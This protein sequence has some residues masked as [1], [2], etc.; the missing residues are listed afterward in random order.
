LKLK[1][2]ILSLVLGILILSLT[3]LSLPLYWFS[4]SAIED[5]LD[6][7][8][9]S[10]L[11]IT[12]NMLDKELLSTMVHEPSL[13]TV[14][15]KLES[16]LQLLLTQKIKGLA[17]YT[18]DGNELV[19]AG[20]M[21]SQKPIIKT[22]LSKSDKSYQNDPSIVSDLYRLSN[23][24]YIKVA[25]L[26]IIVNDKTTIA[27]VASSDAEFMI[28]IDQLRGS[29]FWIVIVALFIALSFAAAFSK[30]LLLPFL[31]LSDY[32]NAIQ[33]NI[34]T[35]KIKLGR[36]DEFGDLNEALIEMHDEIRNTNRK[37][38]QFLADVAHEIK[39][40]L[41]G[42]ELYL[43]LVSEELKSDSSE[44]EYISKIK[45]EF[46]NLKQIVSSYLDYSRPTKINLA[47]LSLNS[48]IED[49]HR[50]VEQDMKQ[51]NLQFN[52]IGEGSLIGDESKL[53]RVVLNLIKNSLDAVE[54]D[55]GRISVEIVTSSNQTQIKFSDNGIGVHKSDYNKIFEPYF[56]T[57]ENGFGLGLSIVKNIVEEMFG[58]VFI[59][60]TVNVGTQ[61]VITFPKKEND[62]K[63]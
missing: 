32:A 10:V 42:I 1:Y 17:I 48:I 49:V 61:I 9:L 44:S 25:F 27:L 13:Q 2:K 30:S 57:H 16:Q 14:H 12:E 3:A 47:T 39:N 35:K 50:L 29:I 21:V 20:R 23:S 63:K 54:D 36:R 38:K 46:R 24:D 22:L 41:G 6:K 52:I 34:N 60:S 31:K 62:N 7:H 33:K 53:R 58:T 59:N 45:D 40:P 4:R 56:T 55:V 11:Q 43:G 19:S 8:F 51:R 18:L 15:E 37:N 5:E 26:N 28:Y